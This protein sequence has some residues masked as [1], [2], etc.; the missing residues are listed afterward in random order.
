MSGVTT[1]TVQRL[2]LAFVFAL[3][4][5]TGCVTGQSE[6]E[7]LMSAPRPAIAG[8][9]LNGHVPSIA[10]VSSDRDE[11]LGVLDSLYGHYTHEEKRASLTA[12][13]VAVGALIAGGA[14]A[15]S[16]AIVR[17]DR[18][19]RQFSQIASA[20]TGLLAGIATEFQLSS[21]SQARRGCVT[22]LYHAVSDVRLRYSPATLPATDSAWVRYLSFKDSVDRTVNISCQ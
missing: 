4:L 12:R 11:L 13:L 21:K 22:A 18:A 2:G 3:A 16:S 15:S 6:A 5:P 7:R 17:G 8:N 14:G 20:T 10:V 1:K 9:V 19:E